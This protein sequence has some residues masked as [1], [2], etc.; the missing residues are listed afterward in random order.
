MGADDNDD[1]RCARIFKAALWC[2]RNKTSY[3]SMFLREI[4]SL[5]ADCDK[6]HDLS[7]LR[8]AITHDIGQDA[9]KRIV[10]Y[11]ETFA[12]ERRAAQVFY[13]YRW[14]AQDELARASGTPWWWWGF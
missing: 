6:V 5:T 12:D 10:D 1:E 7:R 2:L 8:S 13:R 14:S 4:A 9:M 11:N 3:P